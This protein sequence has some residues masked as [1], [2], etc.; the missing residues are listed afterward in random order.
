MSFNSAPLSWKAKRQG[1]VTLS[2]SEA[3]FVEASQCAVEVVYL[4]AL[5]EGVGL[6]QEGPTRVGRITLPGAEPSHRHS[7]PLRE[8]AGERWGA[9]AP[10]G[11]WNGRR[12]RIDEEHSFPC[13]R[14][15]WHREYLWGSG[16]PFSALLVTVPEWREVAV[17]RLEIGRECEAGCGEPRQFPGAKLNLSEGWTGVA[18]WPRPSRGRA[19][20]SRSWWARTVT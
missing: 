4:R 6:R 19:K 8:G 9:Q 18:V 3:E 2:S 13:A 11:A 14:E 12:R 10:Q 1:C 16:V 7:H 5:L 15:A 20:L 17:F